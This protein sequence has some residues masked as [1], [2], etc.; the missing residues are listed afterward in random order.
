MSKQFSGRSFVSV[1][2]FVSFWVMLITSILMFAKRHT[3]TTSMMH[4]VLG[5]ALLLLAVWHLKNNF[6]SLKQHFR[7]RSRGSNGKAN[8]ALP[9]A[10]ILGLGLVVLSLLQFRPLLAFY[11]W[12][13]R[14]RA[15]DEAVPQEEFT[16]VRVSQSPLNA[17]GLALTIDLRTGPYFAWPQYAIWL[18]TMD[19]Q[20]IQPLYVTGKLAANNFSTKVGRKDKNLVFTSNPMTSGEFD[21]EQIFDFKNEPETAAQ[22]QRPESLPVFLHKLNGHV[23]QSAPAGSK[24]LDGYSGATITNS[25]LL[26]SRTRTPVENAFKVRMEINQSFDFNDYYSS[27]RYPDDPIYSGDGYSAQPSVVY[28]AVIDPTSQQKYYPMTLIGRGHHSGRDGVL[29][30][31]LQNLTTALELVDRII[32][33]VGDGLL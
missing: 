23:H 22:R 12:G 8:L 7:F 24:T 14:L 20:F 15:G 27:N 13:S 25:F 17:G 6:P 1:C 26:S 19:G 28:E 11:E 16:Y 31:D 10:L 3:V 21:P 2:I 5:T 18:E 4:T 32:V 29:Y 9:I 30:R 33:E